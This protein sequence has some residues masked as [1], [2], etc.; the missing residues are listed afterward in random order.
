MKSNEMTQEMRLDAGTLFREEVFTDRKIGS[1]QRLTPV[2]ASGARDESRDI[3]YTGQ[4]QILTPAGAMPLSFELA[5]TSLEEALKKFPEAAQQ[6]LERTMEELQE[7]R[8][9]AASSLVVPGRS[10]G[11]IQMP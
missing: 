10:G 2:D 3:L 1:I 9:Q 7:M 6:A 5:A 11:K 4:T 8:R